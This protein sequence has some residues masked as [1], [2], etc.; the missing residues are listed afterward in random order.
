MTVLPKNPTILMLL[1]VQCVMRVKMTMF[2]FFTKKIKK[3]TPTLSQCSRPDHE[4]RKAV[5][6]EATESHNKLRTI[7]SMYN[8]EY[9]SQ[10]IL[11]VNKDVWLQ[12][13]E[14]AYHVYLSNAVL[15]AEYLN[16]DEKEEAEHAL[17]LVQ[18]D[19]VKFV[20]RLIKIQ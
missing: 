7:L 17:N 6:V 18:D 10:W 20:G 3:T 19:V 8:P 11:S 4:K 9:Y 14:D 15:L 12:K 5:Q 16:Q 1:L 2:H 13:I